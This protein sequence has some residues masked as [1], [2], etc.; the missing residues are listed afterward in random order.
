MDSRVR[1]VKILNQTKPVETGPKSK[2][3]NGGMVMSFLPVS[4]SKNGPDGGGDVD[5]NQGSGD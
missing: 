1:L 5:R 4:G 2:G 3:W